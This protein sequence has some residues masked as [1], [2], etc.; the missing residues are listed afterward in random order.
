[1]ELFCGDW[2]DEGEE[3]SFCQAARLGGQNKL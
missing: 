2:K 1:M 3:N